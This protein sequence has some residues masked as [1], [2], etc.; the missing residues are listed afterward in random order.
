MRVALDYYHILPVVDCKA[1][2]PQILLS[3]CEFD[4]RCDI[5][6]SF[7]E[8]SGT[9][10]LMQLEFC[11]GHG[12]VVSTMRKQPFDTTFTLTAGDDPLTAIH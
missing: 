12:L 11:Q 6:T 4:A 7:E 2:Y 8:S 3:R 9:S 5:S 10:E 1:P